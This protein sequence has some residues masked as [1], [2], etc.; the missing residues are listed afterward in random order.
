MSQDATRGD[1][2]RLVARYAVLAAGVVLINFV[3]PRLLPGD[4]LAFSAG[5]GTDRAVPLSTAAR[6]QLR[7]YYHLGEPLGHQL[8]AYLSGLARGDLGR[9]IARATPVTDL[10]FARL[11]WTLGL[12]LGALLVASLAGTALGMVA[13]WSAG[14]ARDRAIVTTAATLAAL[15]EFLIAIGLF[16]G[17]SAG[18]GWFPLFGGQT[19]FARYAPGPGGV[20][21]HALDIAWRMALP[22]AALAMAGTAAFALFVRDAVTGLGREPWLVTARAKGVRERH[23]AWRH[24]LPNIAFPLLTFAGLRVGGVLGGALMVERV[25][26]VPGLGLLT[27][28]SISARDY[29]VLQAVFLLASLGALAANFAV[30]LL[31]LHVE[32]RQGGWRPHG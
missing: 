1:V 9:S 8:T 4:P 19:A 21:R 27:Y 20:L 16:V 28:Q 17:L 2:A 26:A 32:R 11:P 25:F 22:A 15:P 13:G 31:Y 5:A 7:D 29:P 24:A 10:I 14:S 30:E 12:L 3:L 23:I 6:A 18:L